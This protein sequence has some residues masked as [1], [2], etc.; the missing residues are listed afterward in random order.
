MIY[1]CERLEILDLRSCKRNTTPVLDAAVFVTIRRTN[2]IVLKLYT[3]WTLIDEKK[4]NK[5]P[6]LL[7]IMVTSDNFDHEEQ[8][9]VRFWGG[10]RDL[11]TPIL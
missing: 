2:K 1:Q 11:E 10:G 3:Q 9:R 5:I 4:Y 8:S 7:E 6:K